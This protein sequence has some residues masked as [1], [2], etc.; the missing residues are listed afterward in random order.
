MKIEA[1]P[2]RN[3]TV[4]LPTAGFLTVN[5]AF[6]RGNGGLSVFVKHKDKHILSILCRSDMGAKSGIKVRY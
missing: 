6:C 2:A 1:E 4:A 5:A 3:V